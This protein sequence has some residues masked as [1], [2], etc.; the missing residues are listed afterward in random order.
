MNCAARRAELVRNGS[1]KQFD[2]FGR[3][4]TRYGKQPE[5]RWQIV[6]SY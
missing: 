3:L 2:G 4:T 1:L 5:K 6:E